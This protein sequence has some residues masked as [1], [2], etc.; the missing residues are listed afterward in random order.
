M[1][2]AWVHGHWVWL[3]SK[4]GEIKQCQPNLLCCPQAASEPG[5]TAQAGGYST[6]VRSSNSSRLCQQ[7]PYPQTGRGL[8]QTLGSWSTDYWSICFSFWHGWKRWRGV[9]RPGRQLWLAAKVTCCKETRAPLAP[10]GATQIT[11]VCHCVSSKLLP[12]PFLSRGN[13][14]HIRMRSRGLQLSNCFFKVLHMRQN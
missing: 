7:V 10:H 5:G 12:I 8:V 1:C 13:T 4:N 3:A 9:K 14:S 11:R 2:W 6:L